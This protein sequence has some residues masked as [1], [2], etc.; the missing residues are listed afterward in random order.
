MENGSY[1]YP[2]VNTDTTT[3]IAS[4]GYEPCAKKVQ[5]E[6]TLMRARL[7]NLADRELA[8]LKRES[9]LSERSSQQD[10]RDLY[11]NQVNKELHARLVF[12]QKQEHDFQ[13][14][15]EHRGYTKAVK[16]VVS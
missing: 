12:I 1:L 7:Q 6:A 2:S 8:I 11:L 10:Q 5:T 13:M 14:Q 4:N 16:W 15:C 3:I 9:L